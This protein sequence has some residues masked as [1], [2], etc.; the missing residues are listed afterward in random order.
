MGY[1]DAVGIDWGMMIWVE[2]FGVR[3]EGCWVV[4]LLIFFVV[5]Y[6]A[7]VVWLL[8]VLSLLL[9]TYVFIC[10]LFAVGINLCRNTREVRT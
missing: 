10:S 5:L 4:F 1:R 6:F 2:R 3:D 9:D 8:L 7:F